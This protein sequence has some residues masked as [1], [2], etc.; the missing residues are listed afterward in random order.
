MAAY[1]KLCPWQLNVVHDYC[2]MIVNTWR[3]PRSPLAHKDHKNKTKPVTGL[4]E[5]DV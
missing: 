3:Q 4:A 5:K 1:S 2:N